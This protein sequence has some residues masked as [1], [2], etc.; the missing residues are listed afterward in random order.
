MYEKLQP[1]VSAH[2]RKLHIYKNIPHFRQVANVSIWLAWRKYDP[3]RG[4]FEP[5]ASQSI[6]GALL[7]ELKKASNYDKH[8][9]STEDTRIFEALERIEDASNIRIL[10]AI[11]EELS[12]VE[13]AILKAYYED[14]HSHEEIA[15]CYAITTAALQKRK[16][17]LLLKL[18]KKLKEQDFK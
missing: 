15:K 8:Y 16:S 6:R 12:A 5:Y 3:A 17:R 10:E 14:G 11:M 1:M 9:I 13:Q 4:D 7:D 2:L 18:R